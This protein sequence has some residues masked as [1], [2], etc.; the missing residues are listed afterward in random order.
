MPPSTNS[1]PKSARTQTSLFSFFTTP[2]RKPQSVDRDSQDA[3]LEQAGDLMDDDILVEIEQAEK[4]QAT[5]SGS[6]RKAEHMSASVH[7]DVDDAPSGSED[8]DDDGDGDYQPEDTGVLPGRNGRSRRRIV[9]DSD[10]E[11]QQAQ[12]PTLSRR[13]KAP[14]NSTAPRTPTLARMRYS[15]AGSSA[16]SDD[17]PLLSIVAGTA[18]PGLPR[19]ST[20][21]LSS[22][23]TSS[24]PLIQQLQSPPRTPT[25][26]KRARASAF[27]KK[28]EERYS[29]LE[30]IRDAQG[31]P[32]SDPGYDKRSLFV[33]KGAWDKFSPFERQYWEIKSKHWD[34]VVFFKKGKFYELYENDAS[35]A[36]QEFDLKMTDRVNMRMAGVPESS[37]DHWVAQFVAKGYR[38]ARVDQKESRLAKEMRERNSTKKGDSLVTRELTGVLTAGTLVDPSLLTQDLATYCMAIVEGTR[39]DAATGELTTS[40]GVA[41][42]DTSTAQ[43]N[44]CTIDDDDADRSGLETLLVQVNPRE[45]VY[46]RGGAGPG[47]LARNRSFEESALSSL[48]ARDGMAGISSATWRTLKNTC[49]QTT[50]WISLAPRTEFWDSPATQREVNSARYFESWPEAL[51]RAA[52]SQQLLALAAVGGLLSYL[53][54]LKLDS[55]LA[56]LGNFAIY[57][58]MQHS[59]ALVLD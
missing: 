41:F 38:V 34:T 59:K 2:K 5:P 15:A 57:A 55:D 1:T 17:T 19:S 54:T 4:A 52:E 53:R 56:S 3:L 11:L 6:K 14:N 7:M 43:F 40:F 28:N 9:E 36:H 8:N 31:L 27:A 23:S 22:A 39:E 26:A 18:R 37:F 48:D 33:P 10:E 42:V 21:A 29:W 50:D 24:T 30:D 25:D 32:P 45:V 13:S 46:V 58:P 12:S 47:Y 16:T 51:Q 35:I 20:S 49:A 44:L